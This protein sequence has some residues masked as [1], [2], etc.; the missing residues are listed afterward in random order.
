MANFFDSIGMTPGERR[1]LVAVG[2]A[3]FIV[4][5]L[6]FVR[7][8]FGALGKTQ[9]EILKVELEMEKR[10]KHLNQIPGWTAEL[11]KLEDKGSQVPTEG[12]ALQLLRLVQMG[13]A[14]NAVSL[15][16]TTGGNASSGTSTNEFFEE[17][18]VSITLTASDKAL[19][20]FLYSLSD[21]NSYI[22]VRDILLRPEADRARLTGTATLVARYQKE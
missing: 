16:R 10:Q 4:A 3:L 17:R 18:T 19:V 7:P 14:K 9:E 11:A 12:Q 2:L 21:G 13:A 20:K 22:R 15:T 6:L 1:L 5:N 8:H